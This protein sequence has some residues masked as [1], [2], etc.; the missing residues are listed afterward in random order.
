MKD[1]GSGGHL[2][3]AGCVHLG[4]IVDSSQAAVQVSGKESRKRCFRSVEE[5]RRIVEET[6]RPGA[7]VAQVALRHGVNSHQVFGWRKLYREGRLGERL[8]E[9]AKLL[10]VHVEEG[11]ET[12]VTRNTRRGRSVSGLIHLEFPKGHLRIAGRVDVEA[13]RVVLEQ[14]LG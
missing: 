8:G 11:E 10:P 9:S 7:S 1:D 14:L 5:K 2:G 13:L 3:L 6:L 4:R 12:T